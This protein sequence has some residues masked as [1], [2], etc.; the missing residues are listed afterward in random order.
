MRILILTAGSRGDVQPYV[1]LGSG[2]IQQGHDV[3][4]CTSAEF[5][6]FVTEH[7]L[8]YAYM[9]NDL[10]E[11]MRSDDGKIAMES[12]SNLL[13]MVRT[14][15]RLLPKL[16]G[17][18]ER[19]LVDSW[20]STKAFNPELIL[21]HPKALGAKDFA[22]YLG[23]PCA[24]AFYLPMLAPTGCYPAMGFPRLPLGRWYNRFTYRL[25]DFATRLGTRKYV[26]KWRKEIGMPRPRG[27][28][29]DRDDGQIV[30]VL[31]GFSKSVIQTP[32][33]WPSTAN[34][35][36]YWF[37]DSKENEPPPPEL[38][39]FLSE[40]KPPL[41]LGFGSI[42]GRDSASLTRKIIKAV[43]LA[44]TRAIL[45]T[46]WGGINVDGI[47]LPDH[48]LAIESVSHEWLFPRVSAVVHHGGCGTTAAG[49]R[50]GKPTIVC[51]FFGDQPFWGSKVFEL[52]VGPK[53]IPQRKLTPEKLADAIRQTLTDPTM[54]DAASALGD[55]IRHE[56]GV[57][58]A[59]DFLQK[60]LMKDA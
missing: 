32:D 49:F 38:Q 44:G 50:A 36:G 3:G 48:L 24:L 5:E 10:L 60:T 19:Q 45:A 21:F 51:P 11:F 30:P 37:L 31:H 14:S 8:T 16:R 41:Y 53:P 34:I 40:G 7:G 46:G 28:Y 12:T 27:R 57:A 25:I 1:A 4:I 22:E 47:D 9:N 42:F 13:E 33:D 54:Q 56:D 15:I 23:I 35:S 29:L 55:K 43:E 18:F 59:I 6:P 58:E 17:L 26:R 52:G 39:R 20:S 2:L